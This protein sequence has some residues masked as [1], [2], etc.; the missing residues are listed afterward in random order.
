MAINA[1][2]AYTA[3]WQPRSP[4]FALWATPVVPAGGWATNGRSA[5]IALCSALYGVSFLVDAVTGA[6]SGALVAAPARVCATALEHQYVGVTCPAGLVVRS[7]NFASYGTPT[8]NGACGAG[9]SFGRCNA[10]RVDAWVKAA[11]LNQPSCSFFADNSWWS[12]ACVC[13]GVS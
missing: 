4:L 9:F 6:Q 2:S 13:G 1:A 11:C 3:A 8:S 7:I 10:N 5:L 12:G